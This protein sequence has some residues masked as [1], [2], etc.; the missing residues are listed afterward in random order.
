MGPGRA[1]GVVAVLLLAACSSLPPAADRAKTDSSALAQP[2]QTALGR[3]VAAR[4]REQKGLSGFRFLASGA[5]GFFTRMQ[6]LKSAQRTVDI[7]YFL[8]EDGDT[9]K[10]IT[11]AM[12]QAA[13]R[14]VRIRLLVDD[15][16]FSR[17]GDLISAL[18]RHPN[19]EVRLFNPLA[20]RGKSSLLRGAEILFNASRLDY[21]M[22]NKLFVADNSIALVGGRNVGDRYF[23]TKAAAEFE[24]YDVFAAGPVVPQLSATF[25]AYW[26]SRLAIPLRFLGQPRPSEHDEN[27]HADGR[28]DPGAYARRAA[29]GE[30]LAGMLSGR[31]P[32]VW[33]AATVVCDSPEEKLE[34]RGRTHDA[35]TEKA[36]R[37]AASAARSEVLIVSPYFIPGA[38]G[39]RLLSDLRARSVR[40]SVLTNSMESMDGMGELMA[41]AAYAPYRRRLL[42]AGVGLHELKPLRQEAT[43]ESSG[44]EGQFALHAKAFVFDRRR[45]LVGSTNFDPRSMHLNTEV[46][47]LIDS[48]ELA[49]QITARYEAMMS[50]SKSYEVALKGDGRLVW[51]TL[52]DGQPVVLEEEPARDEKQRAKIAFLSRLPLD[53]EL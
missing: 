42:E 44:V 24:D 15:A 31:L 10:L 12:R 20:Y 2:E 25:D 48:P 23:L 37:D 36:L 39:M 3:A 35:P 21:R 53:D 7:Q 5:E 49:R 18:D 50:G 40:V 30:P 26:R 47:L 33:A 1:I 29:S 34:S 19:V 38:D 9:G 32:L 51:R 41:F 13:E 6:L 11:E 8:F 43:E 4:S 52:R 46:G 45:V 16:D 27:G 14:G 17:R 22:H 28:P